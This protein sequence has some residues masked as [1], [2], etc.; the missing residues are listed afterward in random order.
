MTDEESRTLTSRVADDI[1]N[2]GDLAAVDEVMAEDA[3]Y[4]GPHMPGGTGGREEWAGAIRMYRTAFPDSHVTYEELIVCG[5]TVVGR[6]SATGTHT[7]P[8]PGL[9][10]TGR[11]ITIGGITIYRLSGGRIVE[12]WEQ[13]DM[14]GMWTQL[15]VI[16][17]P[18]PE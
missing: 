6:W 14:L 8:L 17:M 12:A 2:R 9:A 11:R 10:P 5:S 13:L 16:T 4:H 1:W 18:G 15:G 7:R 3:L